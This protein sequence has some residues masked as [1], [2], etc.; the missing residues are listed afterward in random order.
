MGNRKLFVLLAAACVSTST[1]AQHAGDN[2]VSLGW[3][4]IAPQYTSDPLTTHVAPVSINGP[5]GL[6]SAFTS[7]GTGLA[8]SNANTLGLTFSHFLTDHL[9]LTAMGGVPPEFQISGYGVIQ[10]P[11]PAGALGQENLNEPSNNP[12]VGRVRQWTAGA[13]LQYFFGKAQSKFRP[14]VGVGVTYSWFNSFRL[15]P[16]FSQSLNENLGSILAAGAGKPGPTSISAKSSSSWTPIFNIGASYALSEHWQLNA[17]VSYMPLK[18]YAET[19]IKA[20]DGTL[21]AVS[22]AKLRADPI[23]TFLAV[24]Y[25]F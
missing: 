8:V 24:S 11:G 15:N 18:T 17:S 10:P 1:Y 22:K 21:L 5:L 3:F 6:P 19:D 20:A 9:A 12:L 23:I 16:Y 14:F 25:R 7:A 4:H 13:M 2:V